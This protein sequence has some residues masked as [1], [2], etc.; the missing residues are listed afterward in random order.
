MPEAKCFL[1]VF[2]RF[3]HTVAV[4]LVHSSMQIVSRAVMFWD[5]HLA[6]ETFNPQIL[7]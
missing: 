1:L 7:Y 3:A 5:F 4:I 6:A 2:T